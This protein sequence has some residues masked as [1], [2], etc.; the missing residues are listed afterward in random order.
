MPL[1][2]SDRHHYP[3]P[4]IYNLYNLISV[5]QAAWGQL[6]NSD[7]HS[8]TQI[9]IKNYELG[10][11]LPVRSSTEKGLEKWMDCLVSYKR[12]C[13]K[14]TEEDTPWMQSDFE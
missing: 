10:V 1:C 12:P 8:T 13:S 3:I 6:E 14:Y 11:L 2:L 9:T 4:S 7:M 5:T